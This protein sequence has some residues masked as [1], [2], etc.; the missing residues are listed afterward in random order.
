M[1]SIFDILQI[2]PE[3]A[4]QK[5]GGA[6][7]TTGKGTGSLWIPGYEERESEMQQRYTSRAGERGSVVGD[8]PEAH[9][10]GEEE[11]GGGT[12]GRRHPGPVLVGGRASRNGSRDNRVSLLTVWESS[13]LRGGKGDHEKAKRQGGSGRNEQTLCRHHGSTS[14]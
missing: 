13:K 14:G 7:G 8:I 11:R 4:Q 2:T 6:G 12:T 10:E 9:G 5:G 3:I 1:S